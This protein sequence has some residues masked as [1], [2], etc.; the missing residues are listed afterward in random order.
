MKVEFF[1]VVPIGRAKAAEGCG[2]P[3]APA[4]GKMRNPRVEKRHAAR[5]FMGFA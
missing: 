5:V 2:Q 1:P 4:K 3:P